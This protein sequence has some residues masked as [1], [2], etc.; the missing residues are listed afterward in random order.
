MCPADSGQNGARLP[1]TVCGKHAGG[2]C[3]PQDLQCGGLCSPQDLQCGGLCSPQDL[4]CGLPLDCISVCI[5]HHTTST[6]QHMV[7]L[8]TCRI[9]LCIQK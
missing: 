6:T 2:L 1:Y 4:Q 8:P 9:R 7:G 5:P 3:S